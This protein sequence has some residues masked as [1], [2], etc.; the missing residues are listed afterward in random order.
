M[1]RL[2]AAARLLRRTQCI[3]QGLVAGGVGGGGVGGRRFASSGAASN[4]PPGE[5]GGGGSAPVTDAV[6]HAISK[7]LPPNMFAV[8]AQ[9]VLGERVRADA[10]PPGDGIASA[11]AARVNSPSFAATGADAARAAN[12]TSNVV[13]GGAAAGFPRMSKP[14]RVDGAAAADPGPMPADTP[15]MAGSAPTA[16]RAKRSAFLWKKVDTVR[17]PGAPSCERATSLSLAGLTLRSR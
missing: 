8:L 12:T 11:H 15:D 13:G 16:P 6:L 9:A 17:R 10:L 5:R 3:R 2:A 14:V 7:Q 4:T 1:L